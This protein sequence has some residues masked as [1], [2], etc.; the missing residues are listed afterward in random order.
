MMLT[1]KHVMMLL[2]LLLLL[3]LKVTKFSFACDL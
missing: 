1:L 2:L 3:L